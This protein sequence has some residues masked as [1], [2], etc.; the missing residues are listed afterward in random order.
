MI[1]SRS[2]ARRIALLGGTV[3]LLAGVLGGSAAVLIARPAAASGTITQSPP[4]SGTVTAG[5]P[6]TDQL[7]TNGV[8][9]VTF[10]VTTSSP[11]FTVSSSGAVSAPDTLM[12]G[13]YAVS[14]TD[15]DAFGNAGNWT[16]TLHVQGR[17][18]AQITP[19]SGTVTAGNPFTDQLNTNGV[20]SVTFT[21][22][23]SSSA[24][25]VTSLSPAL[26]VSASGVVSASGSLA[27]GIYTVSGTDSDS[28]GNTGTWSFSLTVTSAQSGKGYW[29][30]ASDGGIFAFGDAVFHGSTGAITLNKPVV[31]MSA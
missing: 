5:N 7:N 27:P 12:V 26:T 6:F 21:A 31:G 19:T 18:I 23:S 17:T 16:Y 15:S 24:L 29:L 1:A 2:M 14:G 9:P 30:V 13:S 8:S 10:S 3:A 11:A 4:L 25:A 28:L 22:T 20:G